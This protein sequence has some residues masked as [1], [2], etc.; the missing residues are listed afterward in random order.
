MSLISQEI[1]AQGNILTKAL[2]GD[3]HGYL[4]DP[5]APFPN[6]LMAGTEK[7]ELFIYEGFISEEE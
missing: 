7:G 5:T 6:P 1:K 3:Y 4:D 2:K